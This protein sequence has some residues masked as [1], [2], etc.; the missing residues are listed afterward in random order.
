MTLDRTD[1]EGS[2]A[3]AAADVLMN[4]N[5]SLGLG[6]NVFDL[7]Q[8]SQL[9]QTWDDRGDTFNALFDRSW[10]VQDALRAI[11]RADS[12]A[13]VCVLTGLDDEHLGTAA[14]AAGA[15]DYLVK[16]KADG[17][18]LVG[19]EIVNLAFDTRSRRPM[20]I[21]D[22]HA[23]REGATLQPDLAPRPGP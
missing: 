14:V 16:G 19:F 6:S 10:T 18:V 23:Q 20:R 13:A 1:P 5:Y 4:S 17:E 22:G 11:L 2:I 3:W 7:S 21:P 8:L 9:A 12:S 15:Q